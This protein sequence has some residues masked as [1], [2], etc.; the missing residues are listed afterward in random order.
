MYVMVCTILNMEHLVV[1]MIMFM[2]DLGKE[3]WMAIKKDF[4]I[5]RY[6]DHGD[7]N[8]LL[9]E[10]FDV[11]WDGY[12]D[13]RKSTH[14]YVFTLFGGALIWVRR[15]KSMIAISSLEVEYVATIEDTKENI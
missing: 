12:V 10:F 3:H 6:Q 9:H 15:R 2:V 5:L 13:K 8:F 1:A 14:A 11:D 4:H 7:D